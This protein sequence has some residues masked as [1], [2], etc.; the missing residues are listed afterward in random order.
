MPEARIG[1]LVDDGGVD[2]VDEANPD[3]DARLGVLLDSA[4]HDPEEADA[5]LG[6]RGWW[7]EVL[8]M[9]CGGCA[10]GWC[11]ARVKKSC[12]GKGEKKL[13]SK[14][15]I[16]QAMPAPGQVTARRWGRAP[17]RALRRAR[18]RGG[19]GA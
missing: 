10:C 7:S 12:F 1:T 11:A 8:L 9:Q 13:F 16:R 6:E 5:R 17:S 2:C 15:G 3:A 19:A 14:G 4:G 18:R